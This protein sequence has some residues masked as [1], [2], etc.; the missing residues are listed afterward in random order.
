MLT[1]IAGVSTARA[2]EP[3][4]KDRRLVLLFRQGGLAL[5]ALAFALALARP[6]GPSALFSGNTL[7]VA[8]LGLALYATSLRATRL[9]AYLYCGFAALFVAYF[10]TYY[11]AADLIRTVEEAARRAMGYDRKLPLPFKAING[12]VFN[13]A[14]A[15]L[16]GFFQ[17]RWSDDRLARHCHFIGLPL[18]IAACVFSGFEPKAALICMGGYAVLYAL[19]T[20][21]FAQPALIYLA[22]LAM[23]GA[24]SF[25][26]GLVG[27]ATFEGRSLVAS[28]L[29]LAF[30]AIRALPA[31]A[32]AGEAYRA[33][34]LR[35]ARVMAVV[36]MAAGHAR[37]VPGRGDLADV[38]RG[39][40]ARGDPGVARRPRG[41][42]GLGVLRGDRRAARFVAGLVSSAG[43]RGFGDGARPGGRGL[44]SRPA[45]ERRRC[46]DV[47][48]S[49][50][51]DRGV[52]RGRGLGG[53]GAG[54]RRLGLGGV[55]RGRLGD[56]RPDVPRRLLGAC[57]G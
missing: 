8:L 37:S 6:P 18:S 16:A 1:A 48:P 56:G 23:A 52:S 31:L 19:G 30:W 3:I 28:G 9:P 21:L 33:P 54:F 29:G 42:E 34:L 12:L 36:A 47:A 7:A 53:A 13:V 4:E 44:H 27:W 46:A 26:T 51:F 41:A 49:G 43:W 32:A 11:F 20:W 40:P 50:G 24:A 10:G 15:W 17:R 14:L 55:E 22:C 2:I 45:P 5:S 25:G 35:S 57:S 39:L 38:N